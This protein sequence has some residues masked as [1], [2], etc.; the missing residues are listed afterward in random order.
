LQPDYKARLRE[1]RLHGRAFSDRL[2]G[3]KVIIEPVAEEQILKPVSEGAESEEVVAGMVVQSQCC[4]VHL[5]GCSR[6]HQDS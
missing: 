6:S 5:R 4:V 3:V 2:V 1:S